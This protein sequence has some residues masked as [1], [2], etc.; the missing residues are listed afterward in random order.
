MRLSIA[1][2][3]A[4]LLAGSAGIAIAAGDNQT[5]GSFVTN[6]QAN[7]MTETQVRQKLEAQDYTNVQ[8]KDRDKTHIDVTAKNGNI[9]TKNCMGF[10]KRFSAAS[11]PAPSA[12]VVPQLSDQASPAG[13]AWTVLVDGAW[14]P[15]PEDAIKLRHDIPSELLQFPAHVCARQHYDSGK[16]TPVIEC[17]V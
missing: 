15:V 16:P 9:C 8:I 7:R 13:V 1:V 12:S 4:A 11:V 5:V 6:V 2:L 10:I 3:G 17:V 14:C